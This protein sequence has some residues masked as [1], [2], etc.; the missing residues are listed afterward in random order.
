M[1]KIVVFTGAGISAESGLNTFRDS[2]GLWENHEVTEVA[3]PQAWEKN[4]GMVLDFYNMRRKQ[5]LEAFPNI[6]HYALVELEKK[7]KV[8]I[9]T[10]NV[11][12]LHER[13]GSSNILHLHGEILKA[14]SVVDENKKYLI[15]GNQLCLGEKC[16]YGQQLRPDVV[17]FGEEVSNM[18]KAEKICIDADILI[19]IGTSL[20]VYPAANIVS[21][22]PDACLKYLIDPKEVFLNGIKNL[23]VIKEKATIGITQLNNELLK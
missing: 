22:V 15:K 11:D 20:N 9:I 13:A 14:R 3:T 12:D 23:T 10:Q 5:V 17:W 21:Y 19:I 6:A 16:E 7:Y 2:D 1:K 8:D 4:A 18:I